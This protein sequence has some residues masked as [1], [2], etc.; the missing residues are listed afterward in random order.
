MRLVLSKH[1]LLTIPNY[2]LLVFRAPAYFLNKVKR[3]VSRFLWH[4]E[5]E[6][7]KGLVWRKWEICCLPKTKGGLGLTFEGFNQALLAKVAWRIIKNPESLLAMVLVG[8]YCQR[9]NLLEVKLTSSASWGWRSIL[10]GKE[11]L[12]KGIKWKI[13]NGRS[14]FHDE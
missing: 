13:G 6:R 10:R 12:C 9:Q 14:V 7:E 11:L 3:V 8:K 2:L 4:G 5:R 1:V